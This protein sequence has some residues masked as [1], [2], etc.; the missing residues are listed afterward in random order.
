M[1]LDPVVC[2]HLDAVLLSGTTAFE[3]A[4]PTARALGVDPDALLFAPA[5][6]ADE[7]PWVRLVLASFEP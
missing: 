2:E 1:T 3:R 6:P 5:E 7:D 4:A